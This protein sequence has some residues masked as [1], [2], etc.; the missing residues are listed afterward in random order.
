MT[1]SPDDPQPRQPQ[2]PED[3][4]AATPLSQRLN[5]G[6]DEWIAILVAFG[7]IGTIFF[8]SIRP[9]ATADGGG[10]L[11]NGFGLA[12][13]EADSSADAG[14]GGMAAGVAPEAD[15]GRAALE[16]G[17]AQAEVAPCAPPLPAWGQPPRTMSQNPPCQPAQA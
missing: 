1:Y 3:D 11:N 17:A 8:W 14:L 2:R 12:T 15:G 4:A 10:W 7:V 5:L 9:Q 16:D 13:G 6:S